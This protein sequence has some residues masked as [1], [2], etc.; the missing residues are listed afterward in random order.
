MR[1]NWVWNILFLFIVVTTVQQKMLS[2]NKFWNLR[3]YDWETYQGS[4]LEC[5]DTSV[6]LHLFYYY[7]TALVSL[8]RQI[9]WA[10]TEQSWLGEDNRIWFPEVFF[11]PYFSLTVCSIPGKSQISLMLLM[12]SVC[13]EWHVLDVVCF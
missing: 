6:H 1:K 3:H 2:H 4:P 12:S 11:V 13:R 7:L 8:Q 9:L 10:L 5:L